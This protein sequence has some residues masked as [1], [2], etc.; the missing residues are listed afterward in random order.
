MARLA[1]VLAGQG[2]VADAQRWL[3]QALKLAPSRKEL[4]LAFIEQLVSE[5][6]FAEAVAQYEA[7]DKTEPNNPDYLRQWGLLTLKDSSRPEA[8][9]KQAAAAVWRSLRQASAPPGA[10]NST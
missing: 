5:G 1:R 4:R 8:E 6:R 10:F 9:R 2:R 7:L 3:D